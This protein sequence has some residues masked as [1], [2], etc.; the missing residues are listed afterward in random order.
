MP[1][2]RLFSQSGERATDALFG[3]NILAP[4]G[5]TEG[6]GSYTELVTDLGVTSLRYP[7]GSLT[8]EYFDI[9]NPDS[10]TVTG[11]EN[12]VTQDFIPLSDF[13]SMAADVGATVTIVVPTRTML[14]EDVD[15]NGD[16]VPGFDEVVLREFVHDVVTGVYGDAPIAAF[17]I[18]N[19]Y[20]GSGRMN[21]ME[22]GRLSAGMSRV[23]DDELRLVAEVYDTAT[24]AIDVVVQMGTD[25]GY[26]SLNQQYENWDAQ[27]VLD[28]LNGQYDLDLGDD[29]IRGSGRPNWTEIANEIVMSNFDESTI[30]QVDGIVAHVYSKEPAIP[31]QRGYMLDVI[32]GTWGQEFEDLDIYLTEWNQSASTSAFER[33]DDYGLFQ[34]HEMLN[35]VEQMLESGVD[36]A[37]AWPLLQ[38]SDNAFSMGHSHTALTPSGVMF[39]LMS[40]TIPGKTVIDLASHPDQT[41]AALNALDVHA[42]YGDG[43]LVFFLAS[44]TDSTAETEIDISGLITGFESLSA[45]VLGV[46]GSDAVGSNVSTAELRDLD[47]A[48][49]HE[50]GFLTVRLDEGEIMQLRLTGIDPTE[51]FR[52]YANLPDP[53]PEAAASV[54]AQSNDNDPVEHSAEGLH[55]HDY[56]TLQHGQNLLKGYTGNDTLIGG[57]G[58]DTLNGGR[59]EDSIVGRAGEDVLR[60]REGDD[61]LTGGAGDDWITGESGADLL[62]GGRGADTLKSG[63]GDDTLSGGPNSDWL[64]AGAGINEVSGGYGRDTF[65]FAT[66]KP[67][68]TTITDFTP[69]RDLITLDGRHDASLSDITVRQSGTGEDLMTTLMLSDHRMIHL[70]GDLGEDDAQLDDWVTI[71]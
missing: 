23:I 36:A 3:G 28:D 2:L 4:R 70:Q 56:L 10:P 61:Y 11:N 53:L 41:E 64:N 16:R 59:D 37:Y 42:F 18:G 29:V 67:F 58:A 38:N 68:E 25:F 24:G 20:W 27:D 32:N 60:G 14:S 12:G 30:E 62:K 57:R 43:E 15:A 19:E 21:S 54:D 63:G 26:A 50:D 1:R 51:A 55:S 44:T 69:G 65:H 49:V 48:E 71:L 9:S 22:Y 5:Y 40:D 33:H 6:E 47:P 31:D 35:M 17:E 52:T 46:A 34:A 66:S 8:E 7:G 39:R 13:M 45:Q